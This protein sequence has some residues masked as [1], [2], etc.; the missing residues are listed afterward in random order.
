MPGQLALKIDKKILQKVKMPRYV[1]AVTGSNGKTSTVEMLAYI[2]QKEGLKVAYNKEGSNQ[3]EGVTTFILDDCT[4]SGRVRSDVILLESDERFAR[5]TFRYFTPTHT[6][7]L[8]LY[9][10][11]MTRNGHPEWMYDIVKDGIKEGSTLV[12]NAD[13]PLVSCYGQ[14]KED[15]VWFGV[16]HLP[17]DRDHCD[18]IYNDGAFCPV[19]K[20]R[21][22]YDYV[23]FNH[24][25]SYH[26][27]HC[28]FHRHEPDYR[29]TGADLQTG[30][31]Q[32]GGVD[33]I[34][35]ALKSYYHMYNV[36]AVYTVACLL[37][38]NSAK[39]AEEISGYMLKNGRVVTFSCGDKDGML[40]VSK[41]ENSVSYDQSIRFVTDAGQD[42]T[43]LL[44]VDAVSRKYF[45]SEVSWLWDIDFELLRA[46]CVKQIMLSGKYCY[47]LAARFSYTD[48]ASERIHII[49][50]IGAAVE[51][52]KATAEGKL[53]VITCFSD[54][55]KFLSKVDVHA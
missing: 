10:D 43:V 35:L 9:R 51:Q 55:Q 7:I 47:D 42:C 4:M 45:T 33:E 3:I 52:L 36:L 40:L 25:G 30:V 23:H 54:K 24:V 27:S 31:I 16:E 53:Y 37:G 21:M 48:I 34:T 15:V 29:I 39:V 6:V 17:E 44:I 50:D 1:I 22:Q 26:C 2:L 14:G 38:L 5:H 41:H 20:H 11:Q 46:D 12:L 8:N 28:G 32:L 19:C 18:S 49:Q 13:D